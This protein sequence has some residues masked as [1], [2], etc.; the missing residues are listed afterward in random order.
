MYEM[1]HRVRYSEISPNKHVN[2][3]QIVKYFQDCSTFDS[4]QIGQGLDY[5]EESGHVWLLAAWQVEVL[6]YP[7]MGEEIIIATWPYRTKGILAYRNFEIRDLNGNRLVA[8]NSIWFYMNLR[9]GIPKKIEEEDVKAYGKGEPLPIK[10]KSRKI[11]IPDIEGQYMEDFSVKKAD[12]DTNGHVNNA[13]YI[14]MAMEYLNDQDQII[15]MRA[16]YRKS[17]LYGDR[18][19]PVVR[20]NENFTYIELLQNDG[21]PYVIIEFERGKM[22]LEA[23]SKEEK[24]A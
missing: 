14:E 9:T 13:R 10:E 12:L 5:L 11:K 23:Y 2:I 24:R 20:E 4:E 18:I 17:A 22:D 15:S 3:E 16:D 8:A 6:R 19:Y 21:Q 1:K 7:V